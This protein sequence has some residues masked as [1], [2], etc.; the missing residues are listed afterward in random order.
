MLEWSKINRTCNSFIQFFE[1]SQDRKYCG[2]Q[3]LTGSNF[4][5]S[6]QLINII[7]VVIL[8]ANVIK[9]SMYACEH[10]VKYTKT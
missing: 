8:K 10:L 6:Y 7:G 3:S 1:E 4:S 9:T 5:Y 2:Y